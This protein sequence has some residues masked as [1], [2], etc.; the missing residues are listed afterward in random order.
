MQDHQAKIAR[1]SSELSDANTKNRTLSDQLRATKEI[2]HKKNS[3]LV[4]LIKR[5]NDLEKDIVTLTINA[6]HVTPYVME[7]S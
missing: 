1:L 6:N 3:E 4:R 2:I 7:E 5:L